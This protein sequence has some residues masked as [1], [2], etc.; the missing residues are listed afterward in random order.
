MPR[1]LQ[2]R[3]R[4]RATHLWAIFHELAT[5]PSLAAPRSC[6]VSGPPGMG[7]T[8]LVAEFAWR[9][10]RRHFEGGIVSV[11]AVAEGDAVKRQ[12]ADAVSALRESGGE[13]LTPVQIVRRAGSPG[14]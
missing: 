4:G 10:V 2:E 9:Y 3:F 11:D 5:V 8:Q 7:K 12:I 13:D 1:S 14:K 6:C